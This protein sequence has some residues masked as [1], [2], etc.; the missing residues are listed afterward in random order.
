MSGV[1]AAIKMD[2]GEPTSLVCRQV[3]CS[4]LL[5]SHTGLGLY[6]TI[7]YEYPTTPTSQSSSLELELSFGESRDH[8]DDD[9]VF[10]FLSTS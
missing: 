6:L 9:C 7:G 4:Y 3:K 10:Q 2:M 5:A 1:I 8:I